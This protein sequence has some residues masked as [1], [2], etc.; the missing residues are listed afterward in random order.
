MKIGILHS[1]HTS[2]RLPIGP[3]PDGS[4]PG[5]C[6]PPSTCHDY[7]NHPPG[8]FRKSSIGRIISRGPMGGGWEQH[9]SSDPDLIE[10]MAGRR[11]RRFRENL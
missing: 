8:L 4:L 5:P 3:K 2:P 10:Q 9:A 6:G 11:P 7:N 1:T